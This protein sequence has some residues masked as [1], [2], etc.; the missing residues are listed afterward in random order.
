MGNPLAAGTE[1]EER[2]HGRG[3]GVVRAN[4]RP[5]HRTSSMAIRE[6]GGE[7]GEEG[8]ELGGGGMG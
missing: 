2:G 1:G 6:S 8:N 3:G 5:E 4:R 7:E